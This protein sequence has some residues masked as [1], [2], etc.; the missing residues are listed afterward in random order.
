MNL[1]YILKIYQK[2]KVKWC[3][4]FQIKKLKTLVINLYILEFCWNFFNLE[5][6]SVAGWLSNLKIR[7]LMCLKII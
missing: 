5:M 3:C 6:W 2:L 1:Y 4:K 7:D